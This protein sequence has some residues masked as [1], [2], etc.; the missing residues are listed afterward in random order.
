MTEEETADGGGGGPPTA[1]GVTEWQLSESILGGGLVCPLVI[2]FSIGRWLAVLGTGMGRKSE[3]SKGVD[4]RCSSYN[5]FGR[6][7][8]FDVAAVAV[9]LLFLV[10]QTLELSWEARVPVVANPES[11]AAC[12]E[13]STRRED[14][15]LDCDGANR[16]CCVRTTKTTTAARYSNDDVA[17]FHL[18][19]PIPMIAACGWSSVC[20][21]C[22]LRLRMNS[23]HFLQCRSSAR[24]AA[25]TSQTMDLA[26]EP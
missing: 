1:G 9:A 13:D 15:D 10:W 19:L 5:S 16:R 18:Q 17:C 8:V 7:T 21:D 20:T 12:G 2:V 3:A 22:L 11:P 25:T 26:H 14:V 4:C 6:A 24:V 23:F